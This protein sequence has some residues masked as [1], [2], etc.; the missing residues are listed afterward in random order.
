MNTT[1]I[2]NF[3]KSL[4]CIK[5]YSSTSTR[6][7]E[8]PSNSIRCNYHKIWEKSIS[9][10]NQQADLL[11]ASQRF[12]WHQK[13]RLAGCQFLNKDLALTFLNTVTICETF[14]Q[15]RKQNFFKHIPSFISWYVWKFKLAAL[16]NHCR[17]IVRTRTLEESR[18]FSN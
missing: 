2:P 12:F 4:W 6:H 3:S 14:Q 11:Y 9:Q 15:S 8:T 5:C 13:K 7:V 18:T 17:I 10:D 16:Q 1:S